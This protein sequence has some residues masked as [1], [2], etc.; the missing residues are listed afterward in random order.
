MILTVEQLRQYEELPIV[1]QAARLYHKLASLWLQYCVFFLSF[2]L[3]AYC[4]KPTLNNMFAHYKKIGK[5]FKGT[6]EDI[7]NFD[8]EYGQGIESLYV[9]EFSFNKVNKPFR[10]LMSRCGMLPN[11]E[12]GIKLAEKMGL[13]FDSY[14]IPIIDADKFEA[15]AY[16]P[17]TQKIEELYGAYIRPEHVWDSK[18]AK[19]FPE[20]KSKDIV[21][22]EKEEYNVNTKEIEELEEVAKDLRNGDALDNKLQRKY[23]KDEHKYLFGRGNKYGSKEMLEWNKPYL[24]AIM[25]QIEEK[26][27]DPR[28]IRTKEKKIVTKVFNDTGLVNING[29]YYDPRVIKGVNKQER[30]LDA[31][32]MTLKK[33]YNRMPPPLMRKRHL[34]LENRYDVLEIE[35]T[36]IKDRKKYLLENGEIRPP[37][38]S[39]ERV[40]FD[41]EYFDKNPM[42]IKG[43]V[44]DDPEP[45]FDNAA[46]DKLKKEA[47]EILSQMDIDKGT[48]TFTEV[49]LKEQYD[50]YVEH[51]DDKYRGGKR[52]RPMPYEKFAKGCQEKRSPGMI[53]RRDELKDKMDD[54][55]KAFAKKYGDVKRENDSRS[56]TNNRIYEKKLRE[57]NRKRDE[58]WEKLQPVKEKVSGLSFKV[59]DRYSNE[60]RDNEHRATDPNELHN[61]E[62]RVKMAA[63]KDAV[64]LI[65]VDETLIIKPFE[66]FESW[67]HCEKIIAETPYALKLSTL[68]VGSPTMYA[69]IDFFPG[70]DIA[71]MYM[72]WRM[73]G[74]TKKWSNRYKKYC[75]HLFRGV[76]WR[77]VTNIFAS[78]SG[79]TKPKCNK[80]LLNKVVK[81]TDTDVKIDTR[82]W[83]YFGYESDDDV[84]INKAAAKQ[85][86]K[87]MLDSQVHSLDTKFFNTKGI[88]ESVIPEA[89]KQR[90]LLKIKLHNAMLAVAG[91]IHYI[92]ARRKLAKEIIPLNY[93][94]KSTNMLLDY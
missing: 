70:A 71:S 47:D 37:I 56:Y 41:N 13:L 44:K 90:L 29:A 80:Y 17:G 72:L 91:E 38:A 53:T 64:S 19:P 9:K 39:S 24:E 40:K 22:I 61:V 31:N 74:L 28:A 7:E 34:E 16:K 66:K 52:V 33:V 18:G 45:I 43:E 49:Q 68:K 89:D 86:E 6:L 84:Y 54:M 77:V 1:Q 50:Y 51:I 92:D 75:N 57:W 12:H 15:I 42:P 76:H 20:Y 94:K 85:A 5:V 26:K 87:E 93:V 11:A 65:K 58:A 67:E 79:S 60:G 63:L 81:G 3:F 48:Y 25:K 78:D 35:D 36:D 62:R 10:F 30:M 32:I 8:D 46:Y 73:M 4:V 59:A 69:A 88:E 83:R 23:I 82:E 27:A 2:D 14:R 21:T 55:N